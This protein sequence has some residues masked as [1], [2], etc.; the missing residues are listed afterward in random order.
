M[1]AYEL[2]PK[3]SKRERLDGYKLIV[4][5]L[6]NCDTKLKSFYSL[7]GLTMLLV[8]LFTGNFVIFM[9]MLAAIIQLIKEGKISRTAAKFLIKLLKQRGVPIPQE[10]EEIV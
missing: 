3:M 8:Y 9:Y 1:R 2:T 5:E 6:L 4:L 7:I 10:L